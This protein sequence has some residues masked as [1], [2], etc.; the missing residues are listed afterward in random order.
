M[1]HYSLYLILLL[2]INLNQSWLLSQPINL[3]IPKKSNVEN[4]MYYIQGRAVGE[5]QIV[6]SWSHLL[7]YF[8]ESQILVLQLRGKLQPK[9]ARA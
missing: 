3:K 8:D 4:S 9:V 5:I 7:K 1:A 6:S 2:S